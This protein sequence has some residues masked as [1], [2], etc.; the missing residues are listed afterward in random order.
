M[1]SIKYTPANQL[2][3]KQV[4]FK[5]D[6]VVP[7]DFIGYVREY[8]LYNNEFIFFVEY[9]GKVIKIGSNHPNMQVE[10]L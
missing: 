10:I 9:N 3:Y 2:L 6:C 4:H 1:K 8:E 7:M 5:C